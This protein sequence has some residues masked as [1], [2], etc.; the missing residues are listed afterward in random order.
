VS[1]L[2]NDAGVRTFLRQ[3]FFRRAVV[4]SDATEAGQ[5]VLDPFHK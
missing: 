3:E 5:A 4:S 1:N 2:I